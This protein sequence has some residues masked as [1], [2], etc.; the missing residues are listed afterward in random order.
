M[1]DTYRWMR[2]GVELQASAD[3]GLAML[4]VRPLSLGVIRTKEAEGMR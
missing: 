4:A 3:R 2:L 1:S